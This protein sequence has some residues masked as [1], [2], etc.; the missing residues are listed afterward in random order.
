MVLKEVS[1]PYQG[2]KYFEIFLQIK[3]T[4]FYCNV[5]RNVFY[6]CDGK[7]NFQSLVSHDP[8]EIILIS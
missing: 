8:S 2:S 7:L 4:V 6:S 1:Y 5:F 3:I